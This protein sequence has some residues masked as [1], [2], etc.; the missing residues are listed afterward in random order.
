MRPTLR[1]WIFLL[2]LIGAIFFRYGQSFAVV[3]PSPSAPDIKSQVIREPI[4]GIAER[5]YNHEMQ[6]AQSFD[7]IKNGLVLMKEQNV[8]II[9]DVN[10]WK[11]IAVILF[12]FNSILFAMLWR[13]LR[14]N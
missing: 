1:L 13:S 6:T 3:P 14:L 9:N 11:R 4:E 7:E 8:S 2:F 10:S 5:L 12:L